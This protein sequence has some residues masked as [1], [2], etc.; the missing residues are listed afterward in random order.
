[1]TVESIVALSIVVFDPISTQLPTTTIPICL[2]LRATKYY[3][4]STQC[5]GF[6]TCF[7]SHSNNTPGIREQHRK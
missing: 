5:D 1:M 3:N 7:T 6:H 2:I 4:I